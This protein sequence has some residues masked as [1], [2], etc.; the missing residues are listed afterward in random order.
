MTEGRN[1]QK[2]GE[3]GTR[4]VAEIKLRPFRGVRDLVSESKVTFGGFGAPCWI[5]LVV[6]S[7]GDSPPCTSTS[8]LTLHGALLV[9]E[10]LAQIHMSKKV[11]SP[12][13]LAHELLEINFL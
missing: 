11:T 7:S 3:D 4:W 8:H 10:C 6:G 2:L 12:C 13:L 5:L 1:N 9:Y